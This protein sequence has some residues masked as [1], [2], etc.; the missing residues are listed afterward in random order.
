METPQFA[1]GYSYF[2]I[3]NN[4][5]LDILIRADNQYNH[6][7][8]ELL[9]SKNLCWQALCQHLPTQ[10]PAQDNHLS[11]KKLSKIVLRAG[12]HT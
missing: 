7:N 2:N 10:L 9:F 6:R 3:S 11:H 1:H 5:T 8:N 12:T 4:R